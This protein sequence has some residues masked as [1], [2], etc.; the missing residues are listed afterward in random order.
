MIYYKNKNNITGLKE[1]I[2]AVNTSVKE[3]KNHG[4]NLLMFKADFD[5]IK[6]IK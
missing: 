4:M 3:A 2:D 1:N 6:T 5:F